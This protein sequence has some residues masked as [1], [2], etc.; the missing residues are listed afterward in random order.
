MRFNFHDTPYVHARL[1][2]TASIYTHVHTDCGQ[3][4]LAMGPDKTDRGRP[5]V[6]SDGRLEGKRVRGQCSDSLYIVAIPE[7]NISHG[8]T[9]H[10]LPHTRLIDDFDL[11]LGLGLVH[12]VELSHPRSVHC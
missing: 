5:R 4:A 11:C 12:A 9:A 2:Q 7:S 3:L 6:V 10:A 8:N 1:L